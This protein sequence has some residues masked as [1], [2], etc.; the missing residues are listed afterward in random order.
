MRINHLATWQKL[1]LLAAPCFIAAGIPAFLHIAELNER[2]AHAA[3][4]VLGAA[5]VKVVLEVVRLA[6]QHRGLSGGMLSGNEAM[7]V[8]RKA[9]AA[10]LAAALEAMRATLPPG[11]PAL[12]R[13]AGELTA[14]FA[15]LAA[16]VEARRLVP[17]E[18]FQRHTVL[19]ARTLV[20]L[21][22]WLD[23]YGL[24]FNADPVAHY[25][26]DS[27]Y[28]HVPALT[29]SL[30]Q[31]RALGTA[32]LTARAPSAQERV[33]AASLVDRARERSAASRAAV[34][35]AIGAQPA[36][37]ARLSEAIEGSEREILRT[38]DVARRE[39]VDAE[40]LTFGAADYFALTTRTI[41]AQ[42]RFLDTI[43]QELSATLVAERASAENRRDAM[44][45]GA[46]VLL[47]AAVVFCVLVT[48]A[49]TRPLSQAVTLAG[50]I[51]AGR[52]DNAIR[53]EG[54]DEVAQLLSALHAMQSQLV[55]VVHRIQ[56]ASHELRDA[57][58]QTAA[59]NAE[60]SSRTEEQAS[61]I[62]ETAANMEELTTSVRQNTQSAE[63]ARQLAADALG[64]AQAGGELVERVVAT[65]GGIAESSRRVREIT[66]AID[67]IAFQTNLL[68]LNAAVEA[69][70]AGEHGRGFA[71]VAAE[72]RTLSQRCAEASREI[73]ALIK[74]A[75]ERIDDGRREADRA[76][77]GMRDIVAAVKS[78]AGRIEEIAAT[79][80]EQRA[81][82]EQVNQAI[83]QMEGV[84]QNNAALVEE[85]AA[86]AEALER[87]ATE[88]AT[89]AGLFATGREAAS[90][91]RLPPALQRIL[92]LP[93]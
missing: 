88:L 62:E 70:R 64:C 15:E 38:L 28:H 56:D 40:T 47:L 31:A 36:L 1:V 65:M 83:A 34:A 67:G 51:A 29:E 50:R 42:Y 19:I 14:A 92:A 16:A 41:D 90:P 91:T 71:V 13:E 3:R 49:I 24:N 72:V 20:H 25:L 79:S 68:A 74:A 69:A 5:N 12:A 21:E 53:P 87:Q 57:A 73:R 61:S 8:Q 43:R 2:A 45:L 59:G 11:A 23:A 77:D 39:L 66:E 32:M 9:R 93:G 84:T 85:A 17:R 82:I 4:G 33:L 86:A 63:S 37:A 27:A 48:R 30:G 44:V 55:D 7:A 18:S 6:Q 76:G 60:L 75:A 80:G 58:S 35:K 54:R 89:A 10:E 78:V 22:D 52:L 26:V 81:G 46:V